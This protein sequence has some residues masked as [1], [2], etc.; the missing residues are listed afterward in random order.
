MFLL[1]YLFLVVGF[2]ALIKGADFFVDGAS[3]IAKKFGIPD[4]IVG[5]TIVAMGTSAPELATS[6]SAAFAGSNEIAVGNVLGSNL[7]NILI[8]LGLSAVIKPLA[9]D[10]SM[11]KRDIPVMLICTAILPI[12]TL[13]GRYLP[14][15]YKLSRIVG[16]I[17]V[18]FFAFYLFLTVRSALTYRK[19]HANEEPDESVKSFP[20]WKSILFTVGGAVMIIIGANFAVE[21]AIAIAKQLNIG[22]DV[23]ALTVVALGTSLPELITS[24]VAAKKGNSDIALGNI[25]GSNIFNIL[26]ILGTTLVISPINVSFVTLIDEF[27]LLGVTCYL[28]LTAFTGKRLSRIEGASYLVLYVGYATY[29]FLR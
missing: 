16:L 25:V 29:L 6:V 23:I 28:S 18:L 4:I 21:S 2:A 19:E 24:V 1:P 12:S 15:Q 27:I 9:V 13:L 3:S 22:E 5:L 11:F 20:W 17:L 7:M 26:L 8:I 10:S 14:G